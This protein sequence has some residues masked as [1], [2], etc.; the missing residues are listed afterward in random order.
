V[1]LKRKKSFF[2]ELPPLF[3]L[4]K[5]NSFLVKLPFKKRFNPKNKSAEEDFMKRKFLRIPELQTYPK[6]I[7]IEKDHK[8]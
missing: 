8:K 3:L 2:G 5:T 4:R 1:K 7:N 6:N